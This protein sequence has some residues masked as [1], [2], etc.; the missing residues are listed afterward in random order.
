MPVI[1]GFGVVM[2]IHRTRLTRSLSHSEILTIAYGMP[3]SS[4]G[5]P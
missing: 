4:E 2:L 1:L 5:A 3:S